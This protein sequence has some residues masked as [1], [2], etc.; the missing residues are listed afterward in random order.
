MMNE[1]ID[2]E[3]EALVRV[4]MGKELGGEALSGEETRAL[5]RWERGEWEKTCWK[6]YRSVPKKHYVALSGRQVKVL[7]QQA[8][9]YG[10]S[11]LN[12]G[13]SIDLNVLLKQMHDFLA[14][15]WR[16]FEEEIEAADILTGGAALSPNM[17][18]YRGYKADL[19]KLE[20]E[21]RQGDLLPR[22]DCRSGMLAIAGV[23]RTAGEHLEREFGAV[24]REI[25]EAALDDCVVKI[26]SMFPAS[27]GQVRERE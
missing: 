21:A 7:Q 17:E 14:K 3:E 5:R 4:A 22:A 19:A 8:E 18:R 1:K 10:L 12:A 9:R 11:A 23:I 26:E 2:A 25:L 24:A 6:V 20:V 13:P 15:N 27:P 16:R